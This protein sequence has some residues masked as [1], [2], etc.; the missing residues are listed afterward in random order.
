[1]L[2]CDKSVSEI[3]KKIKELEDALENADGFTTVLSVDGFDTLATEELTA[4][5]TGMDRTN[6]KTITRA[7]SLR[8][9]QIPRWI[10]AERLIKEVIN[11]KKMYPGWV[12]SKVEIAG[13]YET[14]PPKTFYKFTYLTPQG[15]HMTHGGMRE[16]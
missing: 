1:M 4:I 12:L 11:F 10:D 3:A 16:L 5:S 14:F 8:G 7:I 13:Q 9:H 2:T 15:H 6:Y